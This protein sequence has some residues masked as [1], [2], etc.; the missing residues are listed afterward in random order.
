[1]SGKTDPQ[2]QVFVAVTSPVNVKRGEEKRSQEGRR[3]ELQTLELLF[4]SEKN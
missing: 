3:S 1:M 4:A 2:G